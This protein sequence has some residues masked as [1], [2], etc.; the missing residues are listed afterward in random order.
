MKRNLFHREKEEVNLNGFLYSM[1]VELT[2]QKLREAKEKICRCNENGMNEW[3]GIMGC[4]RCANKKKHINRRRKCNWKTMERREAA[5]L[6]VSFL[7]REPFFFSIFSLL[8]QMLILVLLS[9]FL[10]QVA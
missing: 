10:I 9:L 5:N 4:W 6:I 3:I 7:I 2:S 1:S 8:G